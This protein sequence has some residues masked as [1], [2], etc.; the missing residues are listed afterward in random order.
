M[1]HILI[2]NYVLGFWPDHAV[3]ELRITEVN[4]HR[5]DGEIALDDYSPLNKIQSG[6]AFSKNFDQG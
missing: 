4:D 1:F 6:S 5:H 3:S 2:G